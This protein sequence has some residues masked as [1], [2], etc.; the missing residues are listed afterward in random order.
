MQFHLRYGLSGDIQDTR[1]RDDQ[2]IDVDLLQIAQVLI[3]SDQLIIMRDDIDGDVYFNTMFM[4]K[5]NAF[6][7]LRRIE[8]LSASPKPVTG[9][10]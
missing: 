7:K 4:G 1:I 10:S 5:S 2:R 8:I 6:F 3:E 9:T